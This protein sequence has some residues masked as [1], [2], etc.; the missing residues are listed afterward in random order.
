VN[1]PAVGSI[2]THRIS[3][4]RYKVMAH[5]NHRFAL[6]AEL[7]GKKVDSIAQRVLFENLRIADKVTT[8][9]EP[10]TQSRLLRRRGV[11]AQPLRKR[12]PKAREVNAGDRVADGPAG[13]VR[14]DAGNAPTEPSE[15]RVTVTARKDGQLSLALRG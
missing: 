9:K 11:E 15:K 4:R 14:V 12:L 2:V 7:R 3:K 5:V 8:S 13:L 10:S 1:K 6:V